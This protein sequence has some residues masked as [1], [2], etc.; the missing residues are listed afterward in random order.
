MGDIYHYPF[1]IIFALLLLSIFVKEILFFTY[2]MVLWDI[3]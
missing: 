2:V 1:I 3:I